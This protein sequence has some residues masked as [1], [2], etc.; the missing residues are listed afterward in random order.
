MLHAAFVFLGLLSSVLC[1]DVS[2]AEIKVGAAHVFFEK[3]K[4]PCSNAINSITPDIDHDDIRAVSEHLA[5][6][7]AKPKSC[8]KRSFKGRKR[9]KSRKQKKI[10]HPLGKRLN[11]IPFKPPLGA[12]ACLLPTGF[13]DSGQTKGVQLTRL[14]EAKV[15][16][17]LEANKGMKG[18]SLF[19][20][21]GFFAGKS[22]PVTAK[23]RK[24]A[25]LRK[26][27]EDMGS[28]EL[29]ALFQAPSIAHHPFTLR[30]VTSCAQKADL[31]PNLRQPEFLRAGEEC[32]RAA[33]SLCE[34]DFLDDLSD[35]C[36]DDLEKESLFNEDAEEELS[37]IG[38]IKYLQ[39]SLEDRFLDIFEFCSPEELKE[40]LTEYLVLELGRREFSDDLIR[41]FVD[42]FDEH[43]NLAGQCA[44]DEDL[45]EGLWLLQL[46]AAGSEFLSLL[47]S[48][49]D[50]AMPENAQSVFDE[51][52]SDDEESE[53]GV[54]EKEGSL[55][56]DNAEEEPVT[57]AQAKHLT[58][59]LVAQF[60]KYL[61][62]VSHDNL[63]NYLRE[64][65]VWELGHYDRKDDFVRVFDKIF[66][67]EDQGNEDKDFLGRVQ[68]AL[69]GRVFLD[70]LDDTPCETEGSVASEDNESSYC[71]CVSHLSE[72]SPSDINLPEASY[73]LFG[74][75]LNDVFVQGVKEDL[76]LHSS[77]FI[78]DEEAEKGQEEEM[79]QAGAQNQINP[80]LKQIQ[81]GVALRKIAPDD[82]HDCSALQIEK[83]AGDG[84]EDLLKQIR[85]G[86]VLRK[87]GKAQ[88]D[89]L[90]AS[91]SEEERCQESS[92]KEGEYVD[93]GVQGLA[94]KIGALVSGV[95]KE[96]LL[97]IVHLLEAFFEEKRY[98]EGR[99]C[100]ELRRGVMQ[101]AI[102]Y[103]R[104]VLKSFEIDSE[105]LQTKIADGTKNQLYAHEVQEIFQ[106]HLQ[107]HSVV[108]DFSGALT[109]D[110]YVCYALDASAVSTQAF[111]EDNWDACFIMAEM[112]AGG[113]GKP[114]EVVRLE[115]YTDEEAIWTKLLLEEPSDTKQ[116]SQ[117]KIED[118]STLEPRKVLS[119][120][121]AMKTDDQDYSDMTRLAG[122]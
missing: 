5:R 8:N 63:K 89:E 20:Q 55:L 48:E 34:E 75:E 70:L 32:S 121:S 108:L 17:A 16:N 60:S 12:W 30:V 1:A 102:C 2:M 78:G 57:L 118:I 18:A 99:F 3:I 82:I 37:A 117:T 28:V 27:R 64:Y 54:E 80:F 84:R 47:S 109:D 106:R 19:A 35:F 49:W 77:I 29:K 26:A 94:K 112:P 13:F 105:M 101:E 93:I 59:L 111:D 46:K 91:K 45:V 23:R 88:E 41:R 7:E 53:G 74:E 39:G 52:F 11:N 113:L 85:Q 21:A 25:A 115:K 96:R 10:L 71:S 95:E 38:V 81:E 73:D 79:V 66:D 98:P 67:L 116:G 15:K 51:I 69:I 120:G 14:A 68:L 65:L 61:G 6:K 86:V 92:I 58:G 4:L 97:P 42:I 110:K 44:Q 114:C 76:R 36:S 22:V 119:P 103:D 90:S 83:G 43:F 24:A 40:E 87:V 62:E 31:V 107:N 104:L 50:Q 122:S 72:R 100:L 56:S 33:H 9:N